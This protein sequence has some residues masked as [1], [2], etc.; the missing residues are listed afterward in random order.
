MVIFCVKN[1]IWRYM[2]TISNGGSGH[3]E[4][5]HET[6][7]LMRNLEVMLEENRDSEIG[8]RWK[9]LLRLC[10]RRS[11]R[12]PTANTP[13]LLNDLKGLIKVGQLPPYKPQ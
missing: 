7:L 13:G 1:R 4:Q 9:T 10:L 11:G 8:D 6:A 2:Q 5:P 12:I 3:E